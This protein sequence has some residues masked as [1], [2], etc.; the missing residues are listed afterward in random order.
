MVGSPTVR[1]FIPIKSRC[2][3]IEGLVVPTGSTNAYNRPHSVHPA[4]CLRD[5]STLCGPSQ[6]RTNVTGK[7]VVCIFLFRPCSTSAFQPRYSP[8]AKP[9]SAMALSRMSCRSQS[10]CMAIRD[11]RPSRH[12]ERAGPNRYGTYPF[13]M[14]PWPDRLSAPRCGSAHTSSTHLRHFESDD[15]A[16]LQRICSTHTER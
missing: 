6:V 14:S 12:R 9:D 5:F 16:Y 1:V 4:T 3:L 2:P 11:R 15:A 10:C 7:L 13:S 8:D